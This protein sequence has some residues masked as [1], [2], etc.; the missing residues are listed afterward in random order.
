MTTYVVM[1]ETSI[2]FTCILHRYSYKCMGI[3]VQTCKCIGNVHKMA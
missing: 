2:K 3:V 1:E